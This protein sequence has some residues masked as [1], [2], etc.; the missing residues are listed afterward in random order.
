MDDRASPEQARIARKLLASLE[1][2]LSALI[3]RRDPNSVGIVHDL[4]KTI[5]NIR[6]GVR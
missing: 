2:T 6:A 5:D 3:E 4:Q 1:A